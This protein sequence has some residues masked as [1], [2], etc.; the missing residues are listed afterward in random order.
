MVYNYFCG[1]GMMG[2]WGGSFGWFFPVIF[3]ILVGIIIWLLL[4]NKSFGCEHEHREHMPHAS[5]SKK[6]K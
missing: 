6:K 3:L 1:P 5:H 4:R 2:S